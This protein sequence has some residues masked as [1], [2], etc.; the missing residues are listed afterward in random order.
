MLS[1]ENTCF[2]LRIRAFY[3]KYVLSTENTVLS[4]E[5]TALPM[6][7]TVFCAK[8]AG[9]ARFCVLS[10]DFSSCFTWNNAVF[11]RKA[12]MARFFLFRRLF[13]SCFT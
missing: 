4:T 10:G 1:M 13:F 2:V 6:E 9:Y 5:N 8:R 11:L 3:G 12:G 7:N